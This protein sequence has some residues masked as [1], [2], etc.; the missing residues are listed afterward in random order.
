MYEPLILPVRIFTSFV[1]LSGNTRMVISFR[2]T[3]S[4]AEMREAE[5]NA[6]SSILI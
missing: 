6:Y 2:A 3:V 5:V 4:L 1:V